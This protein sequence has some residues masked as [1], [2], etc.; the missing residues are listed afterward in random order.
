MQRPTFSLFHIDP[1]SCETPDRITRVILTK[2]TVESC[3]AGR[4]FTSPIDVHTDTPVLAKTFLW[5]D[6]HRERERGT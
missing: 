1:S 3:V 6:T 4:A 5:G 2:L